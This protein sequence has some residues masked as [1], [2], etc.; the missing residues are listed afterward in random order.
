MFQDFL[1]F[2]LKDPSI[3]DAAMMNLNLHY[4]QGSSA[5]MICRS[6][7]ASYVMVTRLQQMMMLG[8]IGGN[9]W[10]DGL[11]FQSL[12]LF[13]MPFLHAAHASC[14]NCKPLMLQAKNASP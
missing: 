9:S 8:W 4:R 12:L 14:G 6:C 2:L 5:V 11:H 13:L 3:R 1:D 7:G 10:H